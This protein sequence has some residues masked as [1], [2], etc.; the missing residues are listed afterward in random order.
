[1]A[2]QW[3]TNLSFDLLVFYI[4]TSLALVS[5]SRLSAKL[6][7]IAHIQQIPFNGYV[8]IITSVS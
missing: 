5:L 4:R 6:F 1:M 7:M 2:G 3:E 8:G